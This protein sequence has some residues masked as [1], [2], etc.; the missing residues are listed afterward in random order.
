MLIIFQGTSNTKT[1]SR[2]K[3]YRFVGFSPLNNL[4]KV[5]NFSLKGGYEEL[6]Q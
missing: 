4:E 1:K 5:K 2:C 3:I 6:I